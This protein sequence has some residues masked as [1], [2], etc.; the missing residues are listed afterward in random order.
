MIAKLIAWGE[1][2]D[3]ALDH[4]SAAL[5]ETEIAGFA[6]NLRF[7]KAVV[8]HPDFIKGDV[9]TG[10]IAR[11]HAALLPPS[12]GVCADI[13]CLATLGILGNRQIRASEDAIISQDPYSPWGR[14]SGWRPN[15]AYAEMQAFCDDAGHDHEVH[16]SLK[17]S[18]WAL[19][20]NGKCHETQLRQMDEDGELEAEIDGRIMRACILPDQDAVTVIDNGN[21]YIL[22]RLSAKF[23]PEED[24]D[25]PGN[26]VAPMP[27]K[28]LDVMV[29]EG[30]SV[31]K[32]QPLLIMEAMKMEHTL[33]APRAG[34]VKAMHA[35]NGTQVDEGILLAQIEE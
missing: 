21:T 20:I 11:H 2:R 8:H 22:K 15:L 4:L 23:D 24:A 30:D 5:E 19:Y 33:T 12:K 18:S 13:L 17:G 26:I 1:D 3:A 32:G 25:G 27:G 9:D 16:I 34:T 31:E 7:L 6:T 28:I 14:P 29:K 10:F 35:S